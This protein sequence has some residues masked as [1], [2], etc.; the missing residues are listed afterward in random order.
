MLKINYKYID[1]G[2]HAT[3]V[4]LHGWGMSGKSFDKIARCIDKNYVLIDLF[5]F[6]DSSMP[7]DYFDT[8]EYAYQIFLLLKKININDLILV[9]HSF[10]GRI[11]ILLSSQFGINVRS[12]VLTSS[13]GLRRFSLVTNFKIFAYKIYKL[14]HKQ[15]VNKGDRGRFGSR[16]YLSANNIMRGVLVRVVR[17]DL[18]LFARRIKCKTFLVWDRRDKETP[19]WICKKLQRLIA[20]SCVCIYNS[21][22]HFCAFVNYK[23]FA[24]IISSL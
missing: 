14:L 4:F 6:G 12:L 16:D 17:Q 22:G 9:G 5:G 10:G 15:K 1:N 13:A 19:L 23:K 20:L 7:R 8:Y 24:L 11:A 2:S 3:V 21:G 18:T